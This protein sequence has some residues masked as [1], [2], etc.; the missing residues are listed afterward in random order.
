M[1][2]KAT[3][4]QNGDQVYVLWREL[5][6]PNFTFWFPMRF[7][8]VPSNCSCLPDMTIEPQRNPP[9]WRLMILPAGSDWKEFPSASHQAPMVLQMLTDRQDLK[10]TSNFVIITVPADGLVPLGARTFAGTAMTNFRFWFCVKYSTRMKCWVMLQ[11]CKQI[12]I[13]WLDKI[14]I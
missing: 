11:K 4:R 14:I 12:T 1:N 7:T 8:P 5:K 9:T 2:C 6:F 3:S 13:W 10:K